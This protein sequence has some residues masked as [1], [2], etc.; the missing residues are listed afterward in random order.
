MD[1]G[2]WR[3]IVHSVAESDMTE[4]TLHTPHPRGSKAMQ[5]FEK[6]KADVDCC[7]SP[8]QESFQDKKH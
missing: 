2:T 7:F 5:V 4:V 6:F 8:R 3:V 1:R